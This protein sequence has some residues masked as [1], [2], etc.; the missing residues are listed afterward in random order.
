VSVSE[1]E[2]WRPIP[3]Y[4][5]LYRVSSL[6]RVESTP[7]P[8][9]R[10]GLLRQ[11]IGKRGYPAVSLCKDGHQTTHE[12]HRLVALA[13]LGPRKEGH[14]VRHLDGNP[15]NCRAVNLA[16]GTRSENAQ[17]KRRHGTEY[18]AAKTHC[19]QGH[20]YDEGNTYVWSGRRRCRT[21]ELARRRGGRSRRSK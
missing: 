6:G 7:R 21:C 16:Y 12:V 2:E 18:N 9:T 4:E 20:P 8:R 3:G 15:L 5:R 10:G 17:D 1:E 11:K 13:F 14:E 19:P